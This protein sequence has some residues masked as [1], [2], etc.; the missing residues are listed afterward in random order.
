LRY[1]YI[2]ILY[3]T[4]QPTLSPRHAQGLLRKAAKK[5]RS[6]AQLVSRAGK[7]K[8]ISPACTA[9]LRG[10]YLDGKARAETM[11]RELKHKT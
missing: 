10:L 3:L 4:N 7:K 1:C 9:A 6:A 8:Q 5:L 11:A 2:A